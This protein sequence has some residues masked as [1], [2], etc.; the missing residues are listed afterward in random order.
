[1]ARPIA[2][3]RS[4]LV[5][6]LA[7]VAFVVVVASWTLDAFYGLGPIGTLPLFYDLS[8]AFLTGCFFQLLVVWLPERRRARESVEALRAPLMMVANNGVD[9]IRDLEYTGRC[10]ERPITREHIELVARA[11][12]YNEATLQ[13][14]GERLSVARDAYRRLTPY[15]LMLPRDV[16]VALRRVD[17]EWLNTAM[18]APDEFEPTKQRVSAQVSDMRT[19]RSVWT[20]VDGGPVQSRMSMQS[21][22]EG[23]ETYLDACEKVRAAVA[24][25]VA[26]PGLRG[27]PERVAFFSLSKLNDDG[28]PFTD[29]PAEAYST[30]WTGSSPSSK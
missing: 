3:L 5:P 16:V 25:H 26:G 4:H 14:I 6:T 15:F 21:I 8:L 9:L 7:S 19:P 28:Y 29:Y 24:Q 27:A 13:S 22:A 2:W 23:L 20:M 12:N 30:T 18:A 1:M 11:N 17:H 10:P